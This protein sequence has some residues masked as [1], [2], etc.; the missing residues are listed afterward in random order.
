V[1]PTFQH[2]EPPS[3]TTFLRDRVQRLRKSMA[4]AAEAI[5][6]D[7]RAAVTA[8]IDRCDDRLRLGVDHTVVALAGGTGSGKSSI[9]NALTGT[10]F[11]IPGVS[12][13]TTS[14]V[15]AGVWGGQTHPLLDWLG[16]APQHRLEVTDLADDPAAGLILLD[17]PDHDSVVSEHR[18]MVDRIA[19]LADVLVWVVDPQKYAD[20]TLHADY[21]SALRDTGAPLLVI[22]NQVDRLSEDDT[23]AITTDLRR[24]LDEAGLVDAPL[25]AMS[26]KSGAGVDAVMALLTEAVGRRSVASEAVRADL[27]TAGRKL[28]VALAKDADPQMPNVA[29]FVAGLAR[30]A[31]LDARAEATAAVA[32]GRGTAVPPLATLTPAAVEKERLDWVDVSTEGL[33]RPWHTVMQESVAPAERIADDINASL[34]DIE[35]PVVRPAYGWRRTFGAAKR[36]KS[37]ATWVEAVGHEAISRAITPGVLEPTE[38]IHQAYRALDELTEL[39]E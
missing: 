29:L 2:L 13:P 4:W 31:G 25:L 6:P 16:V 35:W 39:G 3:E 19:P 18:E 28:A 36:A 15:S 23:A 24:L 26:A 37:A 27:V 21:L 11:A 22:L 38:M 20:H 33:P 14:H 7:V 8:A 1:T 34:R 32:A 9:F 12:R 17:L 5:N 30:L 10:D